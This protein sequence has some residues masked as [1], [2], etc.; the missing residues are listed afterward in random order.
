MNSEASARRR[1]LRRNARTRRPERG[2]SAAHRSVCGP[3]ADRDSSVNRTIQSV[4]RGHDLSDWLAASHDSH[5]ARS[6]TAAR[7]RT[8]ATAL[9][10]PAPPNKVRARGAIPPVDYT[11]AQWRPF[12]AMRG[13]LTERAARRC[14]CGDVYFAIMPAIR[15]RDRTTRHGSFRPRSTETVHAEPSS[16][17]VN[18]NALDVPMSPRWARL[19]RWA[20]ARTYGDPTRV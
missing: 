1:S 12:R 6:G 17:L 4:A 13:Q 9:V 5:S 10:H 2:V 18:V 20:G 8:S 3:P 15:N 14:L 11:F 19:S 7:G 16:H